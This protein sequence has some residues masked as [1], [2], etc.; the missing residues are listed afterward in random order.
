VIPDYGYE[1]IDNYYGNNQRYQQRDI[2]DSIFHDYPDAFLLP[3]RVLL[4]GRYP[5][6][7]DSKNNVCQGINVT[8]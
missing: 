8:E 3:E 6:E 5:E 4:G 1:E 2:K 7:S